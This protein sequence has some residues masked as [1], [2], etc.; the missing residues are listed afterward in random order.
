MA[1]PREHSLIVPTSATKAVFDQVGG[2][3]KFEEYDPSKIDLEPGQVLIHIT[4]TG[5]CHTYVCIA[6]VRGRR[7]CCNTLTSFLFLMILSQ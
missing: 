6:N 2:P 7:E 5:V 4:Y 3:I 1:E